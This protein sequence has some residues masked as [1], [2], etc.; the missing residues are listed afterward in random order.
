MSNRWHAWGDPSVS[1]ESV[2]CCAV[3]CAGSPAAA[4]PKWA[5]LQAGI[6][7]ELGAFHTAQ[8]PGST[9]T[10]S[11]HGPLTHAAFGP[12]GGVEGEEGAGALWSS[13]AAWAEEAL[14]Q[15]SL[16]PCVATSAG[17]A[18]SAPTMLCVLV[19]ADWG[20]EKV[21]GV[22]ERKYFV[23]QNASPGTDLR[24]ITVAGGSRAGFLGPRAVPG[25][26]GIVG[27]GCG[28]VTA[29]VWHVPSVPG[30][31]AVAYH[32]G[33]G[34]TLGMPHPHGEDAQQ[35]VCVMGKGMYTGK[36]LRELLIADAIKDAMDGSKSG[37]RGTGQ[38]AR[39]RLL[40][41]G[42][43]SAPRPRV[44]SP[45]LADTTVAAAVL[46]TA[47]GEAA[48]LAYL[49]WVFDSAE[50]G[51]EPEGALLLDAPKW[52]A[53]R[54]ALVCDQPLRL[55]AA[56]SAC[57]TVVEGRSGE[58]AWADISAAIGG[59]RPALAALAATVQSRAE[60]GGGRPPWASA[61]VGTPQAEGA[62]AAWAA[63]FGPTAQRVAAA[64]AAGAGVQAAPMAQA[65]APVAR[66]WT[67]T[68]LQVTSDGVSAATLASEA[69][70]HF[71]E[72]GEE[73]STPLPCLIAEYG[74]CLPCATGV[75]PALRLLDGSRNVALALDVGSPGAGAGPCG[76][77][78]GRL[79]T[80]G[81]E[82]LPGAGGGSSWRQ[83]RWT[84]CA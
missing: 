77:T 55:Q 14:L 75:A 52:R 4:H 35:D 11:L 43:A 45:R 20:R 76:M 61:R 67:E 12:T 5:G 3:Y 21:D 22:S 24:S 36:A 38:S 2:H 15:S 8:F 25:N 41:T 31:A 39:S 82:G 54:T 23:Y 64:R 18:P 84:L 46:G 71:V 28:L 7:F 16:P 19:F 81:V 63:V 44:P 27:L 50:G 59:A 40:S 68:R 10:W 79:S 80:A 57:G 53:T 26:E 62:P 56:C 78:L 70:Y 1:L 69:L 32:E 33:L 60:G 72:A 65:P 73:G 74:L 47:A 13:C 83:G 29:E 48:T 58:E 17:C 9:L 42:A 34:H 6:L 51:S 37:A 66:G 49:A 30:C